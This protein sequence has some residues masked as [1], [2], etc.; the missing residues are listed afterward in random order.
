MFDQISSRESLRGVIAAIEA[1]HIECYLRIGRN[2]IAKTTFVSANQNR[3][4][5]I[6]KDSSFFMTKQNR[7]K[8]TTDIFKSKGR[9]YTFDSMTI[10]L[11][12]SIF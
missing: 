2:P 7:K 3:N 5:H 4:Y 9:I 1:H 6:F 11:C 10:P 12:L 8:Q